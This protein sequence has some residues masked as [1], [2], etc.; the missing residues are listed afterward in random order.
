MTKTRLLAVM[1]LA[2]TISACGGNDT[3]KIDCEAN[4]KYQDRVE[5]K[6]VVA[7]EGLDQLN[8]LV[9]MPIPRA[10]PNAPKTPAGQCQDR[11]PVIKV[12][13]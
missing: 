12:D 8:E 4:L 5:G 11:P 9:E 1:A 7:P 10:D 6:R 2:L 13:S 3:K